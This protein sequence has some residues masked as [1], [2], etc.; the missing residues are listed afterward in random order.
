MLASKPKAPAHINRSTTLH[1]TPSRMSAASTSTTSISVTQALAE[2]KLLRRRIDNCLADATFTTMKTKKSLMDADRFAVQ[3]R[4]A[5][6]SY[7]DLLARYNKLKSA[8][9][10][11]NAVTRVTVAGKEYTVA[12][13]V[14]RKRSIEYDKRLLEVLKAQH[15]TVQQEYKDHTA[16]EQMRV[17]RLISSELS[18][19]SRTSVDVVK[20]LTDTF[21]AENKAEILDPLRLDELIPTMTREIEDFETTVDWI[22]SEANGRT[23]VTI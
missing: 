15:L 20:A 7:T 13:A 18:K 17:E 10:V 1:I 12:E 16:A 5:Y 9:V 23:M 22:L 8:I 21:L 2:I 6:Q 19:D 11:S 3:S 14:E 4:A